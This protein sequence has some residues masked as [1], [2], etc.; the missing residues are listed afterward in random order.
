MKVE[1]LLDSF[2]SKNSQSIGRI[3]ASDVTE[4]LFLYCVN[5]LYSYCWD[6][7]EKCVN[8]QMRDD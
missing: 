2:I 5:P 3:L 4:K 6:E 8:E 7:L 1:T